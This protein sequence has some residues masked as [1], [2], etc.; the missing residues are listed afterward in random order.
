VGNIVRW[1]KWDVLLDALARLPDAM[2]RRFSF[3]HYGEAPA[4][5][6]SCAF[7]R[8]LHEFIQRASL[9]TTVR[10]QGPTHDVMARVQEADWFVLPSTNE[11]CS[12]ALIEALALGRPALVSASGGNVDIITPD[13][14]GL[15]FAA[16]DAGDL[17]RQLQRMLSGELR[18]ADP[19]RLRQSV[20]A[21]HPARVSR[22]Y[23]DLYERMLPGGAGDRFGSRASGR[24]IATA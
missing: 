18:I 11:P 1:K 17:A 13:H 8:E 12:V 7:E 20:E 21:R 15:L 10:F 9:A 5:P 4:D 24:E 23:R 19:G 6:D 2:R 14:T 3:A 22:Q 16:D